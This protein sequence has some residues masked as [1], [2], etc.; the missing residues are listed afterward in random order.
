MGDVEKRL[1]TEQ[2]SKKKI[3]DDRQKWITDRK[4]QRLHFQRLAQMMKKLRKSTAADISTEVWEKAIGP[5]IK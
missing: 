3:E 4:R 2:E 5:K 1:L